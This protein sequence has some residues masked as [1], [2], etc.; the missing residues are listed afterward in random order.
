MVDT[1]GGLVLA[2]EPESVLFE[3]PKIISDAATAMVAVSALTPMIA[4]EL[5]LIF[6]KFFFLCKERKLSRSL[7]SYGDE[8]VGKNPW[9]S[10][11]G[12]I[13]SARRNLEGVCEYP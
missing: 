12:Y 6:I 1:L 4:L 11:K 8:S 5:F 2:A 3:R 9:I 13:F 7:S 10:S